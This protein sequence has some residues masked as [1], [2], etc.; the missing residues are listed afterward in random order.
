MNGIRKLLLIDTETGGLDDRENAIL[1]IAA[2][3]I[4]QGAIEDEY[5]SLINEG[6]ESGLI[7]NEALE[8]NGLTLDQ[9]EREGKSPFTVISE[10]E[11][12]LLKHDMRGTVTLAGCNT[13]FDAGFL[14]RLYRISGRDASK[15]FSHRVICVQTGALLLEQAGAIVLPSGSASLESLCKLFSIPLD[16]SAGHHA[17]PDARATAGVLQKLIRILRPS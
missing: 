1:S 2:L 12:M 9:I 3:V 7:G 11:C 17:L 4:N 8:I 6:V 5:Y 14:R 16:R 13:Q 10:L 15:R